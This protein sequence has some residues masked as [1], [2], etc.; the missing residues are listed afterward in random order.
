MD[1]T[2]PPH[3]KPPKSQRA[4]DSRDNGP[5][6]GSASGSGNG[7]GNGPSE[8]LGELRWIPLLAGAFALLVAVIATFGLTRSGSEGLDDR[9]ALF[10][11]LGGEFTLTGHT[12]ERVSLSDFQGKVVVVYFGYSFCPDVCPV[13]LT[14]ITAALDS[15]GRRANQVQPLFISVDPGR[16]TPEALNGY[17]GHF[18]E[19]LIG[20][21]G[22]EEEIGEVAGSFAVAHEIVEDPDLSGYLVNHTSAIYVINQDGQVVDLLSPDSTPAQLATQI[23][24][25]F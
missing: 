22:T 9:A 25:H 23:S 6:N 20:L 10:S 14:L 3:E 15:M 7:S 2:L 8:R 13:H 16:D 5:G 17:V 21:T 24:R 4:S 1:S 11:G 19:S 18:H 12:G